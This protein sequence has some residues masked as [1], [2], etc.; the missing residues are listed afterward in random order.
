MQTDISSLMINNHCTTHPYRFYNSGLKPSIL[1]K[2]IFVLAPLHLR[3]DSHY[4]S[5]IITTLTISDKTTK[6]YILFPPSLL[7]TVSVQNG[8]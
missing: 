7:S 5:L 3:P 1:S 6:P 8:K 4:L 2:G